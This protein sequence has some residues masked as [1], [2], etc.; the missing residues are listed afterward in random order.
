MLDQI[1]SWMPAAQAHL[2]AT[3]PI[4][5]RPPNTQDVGVELMFELIGL[6]RLVFQVLTWRNLLMAGCPLL[7]WMVAKEAHRRIL[8]S[9]LDDHSNC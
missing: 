4:Q 3:P 8:N 2:P 7:S 1:P 5:Y 6:P 9:H